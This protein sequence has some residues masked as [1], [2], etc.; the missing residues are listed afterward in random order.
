MASR[1]PRLSVYDLDTFPNDGKRNELISGH[2]YVSPTPTRAHQELSKRLF[3][4]LDRAESAG[5]GKVYF[6]PVDVRFSDL[7]QVQPDLIFLSSR[8]L[9]MY[10]GSTVHGAPDLIVEVVSPSNRSYDLVAKRRLYE[11]FG[12]PELWLF[13]PALKT[14][15]QLVLEDHAFR[16]WFTGDSGVVSAVI[17]PD[18]RLDLDELFADL[19]S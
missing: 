17:L 16:E 11:R 10:R 2:L 8:Q 19:E 4:L 13:D 1:A 14:F 18:L 5:I 6:A 9:P 3:R 7:D 15:V 12:V